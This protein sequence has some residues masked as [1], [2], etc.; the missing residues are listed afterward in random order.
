[1]FFLSI[2]FSQSIISPI[3]ILS[4]IVRSE[5]DKS[6]KNT[7]ENIYPNSKDEIGILSNDIKGF[8]NKDLFDIRSFIIVF[9]I[10][11]IISI[12]SS[13][14]V[15]KKAIMIILSQV[16]PGFTRKVNWLKKKL[17]YQVET[18]I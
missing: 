1:M 18:L 14:S 16:P 11:S 3:K 7:K 15:Y 8:K 6:N 9:S 10:Y 12:W 13:D 2:L 4:K 5:R 17:F